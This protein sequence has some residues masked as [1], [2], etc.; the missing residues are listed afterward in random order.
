MYFQDG[1]DLDGDADNEAS[2]KLNKKKPVKIEENKSKREHVNVVFIG[3]V[4]KQQL[5][6][7]RQITV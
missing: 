6:Y 1:E 5:F 3:H 4:G 7:L 2:I